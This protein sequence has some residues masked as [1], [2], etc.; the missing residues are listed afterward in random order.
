MLRLRFTGDCVFF[1][2][3]V[4]FV[5]WR[6]LLLAVFGADATGG[7]FLEGRCVDS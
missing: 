2:G 4:F 7:G 1:L 5:V 3:A 6:V